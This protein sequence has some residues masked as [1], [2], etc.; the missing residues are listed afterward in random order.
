M[1][2]HINDNISTE[3]IKA[4][5]SKLYPYLKLEF[6]TQ[7]HKNKESSNI[8]DLIKNNKLVSDIKTRQEEGY[9]NITP[10]SKVS[11][12]EQDFEIKFGIN[13]QVFRK[14]GKLWLETTKTD[15]W[16]LEKQNEVG[17]DMEQ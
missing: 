7:P 16:T 12:V 2:I 17:K 5:F 3:E 10:S 9:V 15:N 14:S 6:Y 1:K 8:K 11:N 13:V 4:E